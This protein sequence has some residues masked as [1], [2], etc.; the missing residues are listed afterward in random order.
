MHYDMSDLCKVTGRGPC[1]V[2]T[3][4]QIGDLGQKYFGTRDR[5]ATK[6]TRTNLI[7]VELTEAVCCG[8][9]LSLDNCV[10][11]DD[12]GVSKQPRDPITELRVDVVQVC[13]LVR[14]R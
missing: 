1:S 8:K 13:A 4:I 11:Q 9:K 7:L 5:V 6:I 14:F 10:D 3:D 2:G 12:Y